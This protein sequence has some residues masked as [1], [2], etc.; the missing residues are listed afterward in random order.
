MTTKIETTHLVLPPNTNNLNHAFGGWL[1]AQM[2]L[3]AGICA[4]RHCKGPAVTVSVD[5]LQFA[6]PIKLGDIVVVKASVNWTGHTSMEIGVF[7]ERETPAGE[8]EHALS[9]YFTFVA[10]DEN[11]KPKAVPTFIPSNSEEQRRHKEAEHRREWR[12][13]RKQE[14]EKL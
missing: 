7:V 10:L 4:A 11:G 3:A 14:Q 1:M 13:K 2:D 9:G 8:L 5:D 6:K 12:L